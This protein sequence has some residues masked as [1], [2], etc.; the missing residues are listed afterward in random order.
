[1]ARRFCKHYRGVHEKN[2]CEAGVAFVSLEHYG[3]KEFVA[4]GPCFGPEQSGECESKVYPTAEE[5]AE[6][7]RQMAERFASFGKAREAIVAD[8]G[9]PWKRGMG[10]SS[11]S[12]DCPVC[13]GAETLQYSRSSYN[14]HIHARCST[15][16]CVSWME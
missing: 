14:G 13:D 5:I 2:T 4:S 7:D 3:T 9:G 1:M 6:D 10:G 16:D 15:D 8:C 12:I 11:G